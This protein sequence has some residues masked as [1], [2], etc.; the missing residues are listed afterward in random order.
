M[1]TAGDSLQVAF[2]AISPSSGVEVVR[3][4]FSTALFS[5][6]AVLQASLQHSVEGEGGWQRVDPERPSR[7]WPA[8]RR[9]W[10]G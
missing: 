3:L 1:P 9:R 10:W 4:D 2:S 8:I 7:R 5:T 6:G